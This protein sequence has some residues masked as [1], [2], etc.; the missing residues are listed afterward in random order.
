MAV[1]RGEAGKKEVIYESPSVSWERVPAG[2]PKV[3]I[4]QLKFNDRWI[5]VVT[6]HAGHNYRQH[7]D[8][9]ACYRIIENVFPVALLLGRRDRGSIE[10]LD[11]GSKLT[12]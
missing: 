7:S 11:A 10:I 1:K 4:Q 12:L 3:W 5:F 6:D 2:K 9:E 8:D